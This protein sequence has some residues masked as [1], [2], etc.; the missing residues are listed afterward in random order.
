MED[1]KAGN[2]RN[3]EKREDKSRLDVSAFKVPG[4]Q[5]SNA[6]LTQISLLFLQYDHRWVKTPPPPFCTLSMCNTHVNL[7]GWNPFGLT[8][9]LTSINTQGKEIRNGDKGRKN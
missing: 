3:R 1:T 7:Q 8:K 2:L 4:E 6:T 9:T 5:E